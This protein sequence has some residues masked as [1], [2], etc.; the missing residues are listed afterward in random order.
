M[1]PRFV[2]RRLSADE[3]KSELRDQGVSIGKFTRLWGQNIRRVKLWTSGEED[4]PTWVPMALATM[5]VPGVRETLS[6]VVAQMI[7][8][9]RE[10]PEL[11]EYPYQ[12]LRD[13]I[14]DEE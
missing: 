6:E 7:Q 4:V 8:Q 3:F 9:D 1:A 12:K 5:R 13:R 10:H 2:W 14:V 11:G